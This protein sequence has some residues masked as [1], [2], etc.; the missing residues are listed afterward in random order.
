MTTSLPRERGTVAHRGAEAAIRAA[1][2]VTIQL[3]NQFFE[4]GSAMPE[5][6]PLD[7]LVELCEESA[8]NAAIG[9]HAHLPELFKHLA[10]V[11]V[12]QQKT[13]DAL[14]EEVEKLVNARIRD[15]F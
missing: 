13:I 9:G 8:R 14:E 11:L 15:R 2:E 10:T 1:A 6:K 12:A 7:R 5:T 4:L 3:A